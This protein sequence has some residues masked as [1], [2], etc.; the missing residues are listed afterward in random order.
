[1]TKANILIVEDEAIIASVIAAA[2]RKFEYEVIDILN[3]G[4]AAVT[5]ALKKKPDLI[6]ID[7]R[8]QG[9]VDG[10]TAA[11][12]IQEQMDIPIIYLTAYADE[13]TLERAKKTKPYGYITK[14]FQ[15]I[16]LK[17][18]IE[19]ALY[20]HA[21]EMQLK[22]S[23]SKFRSLF[24]NS[25]DVIYISDQTGNLLEINPAGL[26]FFG[27]DHEEIMGIKPDQLYAN[28]RD[29]KSF[30]AQIK[31]KKSLKEYELRLKNK[32]G[33]IIF[34]LETVNT[35]TDKDGKTSGIQGIIRDITE[36]KKHEETLNLL[37]TA[38]N[39][40]SEAV[41][42]TDNAGSIVYT[43]PAFEA[44]TGYSVLEVLGKNP[45]F[46]KSA[47]FSEEVNKQMWDTIASGRSWVGEFI[48]QHKDGS[49]YHQRSI[50]SPVFDDQGAISHYVNIASDITK[51][52]KLEEQ[53]IQAAKM[54]SLG[55][56]ASGIAHDFNNYL[57][58]INGYS[59]M[60]LYENENNKNSERLRVILQAGMNASKLV[61]KILGFSRRQTAAP[62][63]IDV[64]NT[65]K[66]LERMVRR[67]LGD[68]IELKLNLHPEAG[69]IFI[70]S[71][72]IEQ[73]L[74]NLVLN[75][76]DAMPTGGRLALETVPLHV[77]DDLAA[78]HPGMAPGEYA[79]IRVHDS[80][81]GMEPQVLARIF[82]P[83]FTTK[84]KGEGTG[85]GL[86]SVFG[87]LSQNHGAVWAESEPGRGSTFQILLPRIAEK[88]APELAPVAEQRFDGRSVLLVEDEQVIRELMREILESL[89]MRV[90]VAADGKQALK[91]AAET[92]RIDLLFCDV[93]LP[94]LSG[95]EVAERVQKL[96]PGTA[97]IFTSGHSEGYLK[98]AG[99]ELPK[100]HFIEKPS[101]RT[102]IVAKI[103]EL[104]G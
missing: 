21:F 30:Y 52:K 49:L 54:D 58:I 100:V 59:E 60:L 50:V 101:S 33:D 35:I 86:A 98:R 75:A 29:R 77:D 1:M 80:G 68:E 34:G 41:V 85:L 78:G 96:H 25:Q 65:M 22:A 102:A 27:Y 88:A 69:R 94:G 83:F 20:K 23:E 6:L 74:I 18:T 24:E 31:N 39:S 81:S 15:E 73:V 16:E 90:H 14:P 44:L 36:K 38:I 87:I 46:L 4:E 63:V 93:V 17:T 12:Q 66:D 5:K 40:S 103:S 37:Q 11:E 8:L 92:K 51:E 10:I 72:Q 64:N 48:N 2:L 7:I 82:E 3:T 95:V 97:V 55:R 19:M 42:I 70:D 84:P 91:T 79:V 47:K 45:S 26:N 89:G 32:K 71:M 62:T 61:A 67:L 99:L 9:A 13:P 53:L 57:T 28:P 104:L 56:L 43:N 76:R